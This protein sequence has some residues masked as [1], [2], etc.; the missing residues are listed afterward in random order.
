[1]FSFDTILNLAWLLLAASSVAY[2]AALARQR[3]SKSRFWQRVRPGLALFIVA[4]SLFPCISAT[5]DS[6]RFELIS[7]NLQDHGDS[8]SP[9]TSTNLVRLLETLESFQVS[10]FQAVYLV[11]FALSL[12]FLARLHSRDRFLPAW[13]SRG[14]PASLNP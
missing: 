9:K 2:C 3:Q 14:P 4:V 7:A 5:D 8:G 6:L 11:L 13:S 12:V 10:V 1:M